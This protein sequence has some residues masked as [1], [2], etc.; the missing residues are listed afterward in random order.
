MWQRLSKYRY[1]TE[2][3]RSRLKVYHG[4]LTRHTMCMC[5]CDSNLKIGHMVWNDY[6]STQFNTNY[7]RYT[8]N[9]F[10]PKSVSCGYRRQTANCEIP[11]FHLDII[12]STG[13][14]CIVVAGPTFN[15][16]IVK[17]WWYIKHT[18]TLFWWFVWKKA[19]VHH[20]GSW[21]TTS[22]ALTTFIFVYCVDI[23]SM[24]T[25]YYVHF[26]RTWNDLW[27]YSKCYL[28]ITRNFTSFLVP[29]FVDC[30]FVFAELSTNFL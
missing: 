5:V 21:T 28:C 20:S 11:R 16:Y 29:C 13:S 7:Y 30:I 12:S 19:I 27:L 24:S 4:T 6:E 8:S 22:L 14:V 3:S 15:V 9:L 1:L 17:Y 18:I 25:V 26:V 10:V 2:T 23:T